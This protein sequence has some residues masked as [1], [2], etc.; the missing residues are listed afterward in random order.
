MDDRWI[1]GR[2]IE[3]IVQTIR[4]GRPN[5]MP[6]FRGKVPDDQI[7]ELAAYVR[8]MSGLEPKAAAPGR[9]DDLHPHPAENRMP[10]PSPDPGGSLASGCRAAT[11]RARPC[12]FAHSVLWRSFRFPHARAGN[13]HSILMGHKH[14][15]WKSCSGFSWQFS[16]PFGCSPWWGCLLRC[17]A[18]ANRRPTLWRRIRVR[19][20]RMTRTIAV[21]VA[22][23]GVT[24]L[25]LTGLSY[26]YQKG[27]FQQP[28]DVLTIKITGHQWWW[29]VDYE[30]PQPSRTFTTANEI[31]IPVGEPVR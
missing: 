12:V 26:A 1:Y 14:G 13:R 17:G 23:T 28:A 6:S 18:A 4:E 31:H 2:R 16:A 30:D 11:I 22:L 20:S 15:R 29:Q 27:I 8:S 25:G 7:W 9:N 24:V 5:G 19:Q 10:P 21:L 3:N